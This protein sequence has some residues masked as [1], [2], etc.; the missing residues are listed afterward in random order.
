M[1]IEIIR[2]DNPDI[3]IQR[4]YQEVSINIHNIEEEKIWRVDMLSKD[5]LEKQMLI[6]TVVPEII[7]SMVWDKMLDLDDKI[8]Y[9]EDRLIEIDLL[10]AKYADGNNN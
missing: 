4:T 5:R 3:V 9:S 2:T 10:L 7:Q 1:D 6:D 8:K